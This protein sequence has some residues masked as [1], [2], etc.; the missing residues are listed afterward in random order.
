MRDPNCFNK[1]RKTHP[2]LGPGDNE[3][4]YCIVPLVIN[5]KITHQMAA[6]VI[7]ST[8]DG[9]D[10][11]SISLPDRCPTWE[12][13]ILIKDI[14]FK[15]DEIAIEYHPAKSRYVNNH[16]FCLHL[17]RPQL[18]KFPIPPQWMV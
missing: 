2:Q 13:M 9:W 10:H 6:N 14:F 1:Y 3:G 4:G 5:G 12:E 15:E 7:F 17:W 11:V 16:P 8:G 18:V